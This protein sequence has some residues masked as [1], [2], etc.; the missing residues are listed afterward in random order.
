MRHRIISVEIDEWD[1]DKKLFFRQVL[2]CQK[3][4]FART[5]KL[6]R[7]LMKVVVY[8]YFF[9]KRALNLGKELCDINWKTS[10]A[11]VSNTILSS[12]FGGGGR[13]EAREL[14]FSSTATTTSTDANLC[15]S[16]VCPICVTIV[17][18]ILI[19]KCPLGAIN[20]LWMRSACVS[21]SLSGS[22][23]NCRTSSQNFSGQWE[24]ERT[25][26]G[27]YVMFVCALEGECG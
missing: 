12:C 16:N 4:V 1:N 8:F 5:A 11:D 3:Y 10:F 26:P 21:S 14:S 17:L 24:E 6:S 13:E 25:S 18:G 23:R 19:C 22:F 27:S 15:L 9:W 7:G 20:F 2:R